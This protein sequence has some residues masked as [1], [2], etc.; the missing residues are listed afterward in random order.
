MHLKHPHLSRYPH[1]LK[2]ARMGDHGRLCQDD[3]FEVFAL[4]CREVRRF[5]GASS[6]AR[7]TKHEQFCC[8]ADLGSIRIEDGARFVHI[9]DERFLVCCA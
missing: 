9:V 5:L 7:M 1:A 8:P 3:D 6:I 4:S 2:N